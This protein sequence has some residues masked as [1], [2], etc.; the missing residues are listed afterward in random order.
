MSIIRYIERLKAMQ[1]PID[2]HVSL[3]AKQSLLRTAVER[4]PW[5][6]KVSLSVDDAAEA[7]IKIGERVSD[8]NDSFGNESVAHGFHQAALVMS[9]LDFVRI[10]FIYLAAFILNEKIPFKLSN[11][12]RW[13]YSGFLLSLTIIALVIPVT[14]PV[15]A[16]VGAG[17]GF[18]FGGFLL[19]RTLY[20]R[21]TLGRE[22]RELHMQLWEEEET[23]RLLQSAASKL[24]KQLSASPHD[25][26][27]ILKCT[28]LEKDYEA[29]KSLIL[30]LKN[31]ELRINQK[32]ERVGMMPVM[33]KTVSLGLTSLSIIG[34][35][36]SLFF[37]STGQT[38]LLGVAIAG[39]IYLFARL[40]PPL[41][42][43]FGHW[44]L[45][46]FNSSE[47]SAQ[48]DE[49]L[50]D[51]NTLANLH[52]EVLDETEEL[53]EENSLTAE[54]L[55][56]DKNPTVSHEQESD[57]AMQIKSHRSFDDTR[58]DESL[59][60]K[61]VIEQKTSDD[62]K[63]AETEHLSNTTKN[64]DQ[65]NETGLEGEQHPSE[66]LHGLM[67]E[68]QAYPHFF[69]PKSKQKLISE[70]KPQL[71]AVDEASKDEEEQEAPGEHP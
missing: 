40:T 52:R 8:L 67:G 44:L 70:P 34:L 42:R 64:Q 5:L 62:H 24:E 55:H 41:L 19:I 4:I 33:D 17:T 56:A 30:E 58:Q 3:K 23:M 26:S 48:T 7:V 32:I 35:V 69:T 66:N 15:I 12:A 13:M 47:D 61:Q 16:F 46:K 53:N 11:N 18:L 9:A 45:N 29:Q 22:Q 71:V 36:L 20:T 57:S 54:H 38:V 65:T 31:K 25:E 50:Y 68:I 39:G 60:L 28:E 14:A 1:R 2:Y 43:A 51:G 49:Q 37:L 59:A 63:E 21:Y 27:M 10:P 6:S